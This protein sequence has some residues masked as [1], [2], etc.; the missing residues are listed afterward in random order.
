M[1]NRIGMILPKSISEDD[2][3]RIRQKY[4]FPL[5]AVINNNTLNSLLQEDE[6][7][8]DVYPYIVETGMTRYRQYLMH[9]ET[10]EEDVNILGFYTYYLEIL[11]ITERWMLDAQ[12]WIEIIKDLN[13]NFGIDKIGIINFHATDLTQN[14]DFSIKP[15]IKTKISKTN[16]ITMM[17]LNTETIYIFI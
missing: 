16:A 10:M 6:I 8:Y 1:S 15:R 12:K 13:D 9:F 14:I 5:N 17:K 2:L 11:E 4:S 3:N 7:Y